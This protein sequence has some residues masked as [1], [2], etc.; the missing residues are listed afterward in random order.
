MKPTPL[1]H[2]RLEHLLA[3]I[4]PDDREGYE[5]DFLTDGFQ[6]P[7]VLYGAGETAITAAR[8]LARRGVKVAAMS[9][10]REER[11]GTHL[12][13]VP[14]LSPTEAAA[15]YG[16]E[17]VFVLS[18]RASDRA[19]EEAAAWLT[20]LGARRV[21]SVMHLLEKWPELNGWPTLPGSVWRARAD[22][23]RRVHDTLADPVSR[24]HFLGHV[25][26]RTHH[27]RAALPIG[28]LSDQ[29][30]VEDLVR[31]QAGEC[32]IDGGAFDG[33]SL[34]TFLERCRRVGDFGWVEAFEPDAAT[35]SKLEGFVAGLPAATRARVA[36]HRTALADKAGTLRFQDDGS[37]SA[38]A[39]ASAGVEV[40]C[41]AL[42]DLLEGRTPTFL[43]LDLEGGEHPALDGLQRT[44][45]QSRPIVA[46]A[47]YHHPEDLLGLPT[48]LMD[49]LQGYRFH[50]RSHNRFG[51]DVILYAVPEER[52]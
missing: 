43:K 24:A 50:L 18:Y 22:V 36:I 27:E 26:F 49:T 13:G 21:V 10:R 16:E 40:P 29:Y 38:K 3:T 23:V 8:G 19:W 7:L 33:D 17:G 14:V 15:T 25:R 35:F 51:V 5:I 30:F 20:G 32:F 52:A 34:G 39:D 6:R 9:D 45:A 28:E 41:V 47:V 11:W 4:P 31:L 2:A 48:R 42:D 37:H 46:I 1:E 12:G 44:L